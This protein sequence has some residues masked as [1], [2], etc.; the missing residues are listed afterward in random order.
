MMMRWL[1]E[2]E[3]TGR[4][5]EAVKRALA[6]GVRT[7]DLGGRCSTSEVTGAVTGYLMAKES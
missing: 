2:L 7:P 6:A 4:I 5:E 1:G 3:A